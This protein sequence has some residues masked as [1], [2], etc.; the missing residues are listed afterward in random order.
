MPVLSEPTGVEQ[1]LLS[2]VCTVWRQSAHQVLVVVVLSLVISSS[3]A[4]D[5]VF[6]TRDMLRI[7]AQENI[8]CSSRP[9]Q[10]AKNAKH[11]YFKN[12]AKRNMQNPAIQD[13][14]AEPL[15]LLLNR[16]PWPKTCTFE[17]KT[18]KRKDK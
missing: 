15:T 1:L 16:L 18:K 11:N 10:R 9:T 14:H 7:M 17:P 8:M 4:R 6:M 3:C 5:C 13:K 12:N 2:A